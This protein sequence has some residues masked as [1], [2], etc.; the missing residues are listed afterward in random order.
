S[1]TMAST[2]AS[3]QMLAAD[4]KLDMDDRV[5]E[6]LPWFRMS[7]PYITHEM[8]IRD[9]LALRSGLSLGAGDLL[10]W[11]TTTYSNRE[12]AERLKDVP[13]TGGFRAQYAYDNI[14]SEERRVG[15]QRRRW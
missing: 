15:Q 9:L 14:R 11:P 3:L 1:S 5:V 7:D 10:Y 8:R 12:V 6:H 2:A 4:G 13:I